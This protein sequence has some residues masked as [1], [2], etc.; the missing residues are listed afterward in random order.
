[1]INNKLKIFIVVFLLSILTACTN[2]SDVILD[3]NEDDKEGQPL[4][5]DQTT[6]LTAKTLWQYKD[7][8]HMLNLS[9]DASNH[10][11]LTDASMAA[12]YQSVAIETKRFEALVLSWNS[13]K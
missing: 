9:L 6:T 4:V 10:M 11:V 2:M 1:M 7:D 13:N 8:A 5:I 3:E 12:T